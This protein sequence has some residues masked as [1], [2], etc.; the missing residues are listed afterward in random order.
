MYT[1]MFK[2]KPIHFK[3]GYTLI[4]MKSQSHNEFWSP[5][6]EKIFAK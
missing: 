1:Y 2:M 5:L 6:L 4:Y 3:T